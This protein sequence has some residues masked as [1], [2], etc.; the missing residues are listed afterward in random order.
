MAHAHIRAM[1]RGTPGESY[2]IAGPPH[3]LIDALA[4]AEK[5][6]GI[7]AP[8]IHPGPSMM[9][10]MAASMDVLGAALPLPSTFT[11]EA[12]RVSSGVTY[13]GDN[14]KA[15]AK[16]GYEPRPLAQGLPPTLAYDMQRLGIAA[17][18]A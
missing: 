15:K 3:T 16:L 12:L 5:T 18:R 11:G 7:K 14:G 4:L 17:R 10:A 9:R 6:T 2:I 1:E 8:R 13:I